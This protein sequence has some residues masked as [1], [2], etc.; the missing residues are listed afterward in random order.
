MSTQTS[1]GP[2]TYEVTYIPEG[3]SEPE[4]HYLPAD[5]WPADHDTA[6]DAINARYEADYGEVLTIFYRP[7][8]PNERFPAGRQLYG[9]RRYGL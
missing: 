3:H 2:N 6:V 9:A 4:V 1:A 5:E 7:N 8:Q